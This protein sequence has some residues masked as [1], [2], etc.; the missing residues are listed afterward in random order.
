MES[1]P[2]I[3]VLLRHHRWLLCREHV[4]QLRDRENEI[5]QAGRALPPSVWVTST[6][7]ER[8]SRRPAPGPLQYRGQAA[9]IFL[10]MVV[11]RELDVV[12]EM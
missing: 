5:E 4:T 1:G 3:V 10:L 6:T 12:R 9:F 7:V 2:A 8:S 11:L